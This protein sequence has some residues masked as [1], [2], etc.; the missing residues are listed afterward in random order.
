MFRHENDRFWVLASLPNLNLFAA[1]HGNGLIVFRLE[2]DC[3]AFA[4]YQDSLY[5]IQDKYVRSY[6]FNTGADLGLLSV[7]NFGSAYVPPWTLSFN[8]VERAVLVRSSLDNGLY[9][10]TA[11][12]QQAP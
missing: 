9:E 5:Y 7:R 11:L 10:L 4:V 3:P 8:L 12:S 1:G 6:D 2:R